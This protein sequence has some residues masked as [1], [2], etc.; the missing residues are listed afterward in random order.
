MNILE[1]EHLP[2]Y[3]SMEEELESTFA[4]IIGT[5]HKSYK[6]SQDIAKSIFN[7]Q[8]KARQDLTYEYDESED[9]IDSDMTLSM[10]EEIYRLLISE[11]NQYLIQLENDPQ[12]ENKLKS[13]IIKFLNT[14]L[15][16]DFPDLHKPKKYENLIE[17]YLD[18]PNRFKN[19]YQNVIEQLKLI[20][21]DS[22]II[23]KLEEVGNPL[24]LTDSTSIKEIKRMSM[25]ERSIFN[26][27][28]SK[29]RKIISPEISILRERFNIPHST[30]VQ[31]ISKGINE[32][33]SKL[34]EDE[35]VSRFSKIILS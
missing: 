10:D 28:R 32:L 31:N 25:E 13:L 17:E 6:V 3:I 23:K 18:L 15:Y 21:P 8:G 26:E 11:I 35:L 7:H 1:H 24:L 14:N 30:Y 20:N 19:Y 34:E 22:P 4:S 33:A 5:S 16:L 27:E 12:S 9:P 29:L 2:L